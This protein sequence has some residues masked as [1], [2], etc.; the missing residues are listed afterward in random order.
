[1]ETHDAIKALRAIIDE[2]SERPNT[3]S[4]EE[5]IADCALQLGLILQ[6]RTVERVCTCGLENAFA[7]KGKDSHE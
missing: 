7:G 3:Y 6:D 5:V 2:V 4:I 1:M